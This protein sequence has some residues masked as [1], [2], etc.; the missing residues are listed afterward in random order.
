MLGRLYRNI[1]GAKCP[2]GKWQSIG[3][4]AYRWAITNLAALGGEI[5]RA[6]WGASRALYLHDYRTRHDRS[7]RGRLPT[8]FDVHPPGRLIVEATADQPFVFRQ[9]RWWHTPRA[10]IDR[11]DWEYREH[12]FLE[13]T[14]FPGIA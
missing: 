14:R 4:P 13:W 10:D 11:N 3:S 2:A 1:L 9:R 8:D 5:R 6:E 12:S 7:I